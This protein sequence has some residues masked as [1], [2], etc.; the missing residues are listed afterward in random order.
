MGTS[1]ESLERDGVEGLIDEDDPERILLGKE[2]LEA[3]VNHFGKSDL[4]VILGLKETR[5]E[6]K[7]LGIRYDTYRKRLQR[8]IDIYRPEK[9]LLGQIIF[10]K[11]KKLHFFRF[12]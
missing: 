8:K 4:A 6:A 5:A 3:A 10:N 9:P 12:S 1:I 7:R 2:L 11:L